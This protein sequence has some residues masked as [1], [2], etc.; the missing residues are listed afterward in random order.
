MSEEFSVD[1][2]SELSFQKLN[3]NEHGVTFSILDGGGINDL[4]VS[5]DEWQSRYSQLPAK[6]TILRWHIVVMSQG[7]SNH[8]ILIGNDKA[9]RDPYVTSTVVA[10]APDCSAL[11][12]KSGSHYVLEDRSNDEEPHILNVL[13]LVRALRGWGAGAV[14]KDWPRVT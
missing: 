7:R 9:H 3:D 1:R 12:T 13:H 5:H 10:I 8:P 11:I 14:V 2:L 4:A 6:E